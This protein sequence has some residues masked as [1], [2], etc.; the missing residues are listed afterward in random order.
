L[1]L[2]ASLE[3]HL[4]DGCNTWWHHGAGRYGVDSLRELSTIWLIDVI[5]IDLKKLQATA[6]SL[7]SAEPDRQWI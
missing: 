4:T 2:K 7:F 5:G 1:V 3:T 6:S